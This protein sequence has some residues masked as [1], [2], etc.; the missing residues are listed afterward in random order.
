M[1]LYSTLHELLCASFE[2][3]S[4]NLLFQNPAVPNSRDLDYSTLV[5]RCP[6]PFSSSYSTLCTCKFL[7]PPRVAESFYSDGVSQDDLRAELKRQWSIHTAEVRGMRAKEWPSGAPEP[8]YRRFGRPADAFTLDNERY[9]YWGSNWDSLWMVAPL[10]MDA[11]CTP[12]SSTPCEH[13]NSGA[14]YVATRLRMNLTD[15]NLEFAVLCFAWARLLLPTF[16]TNAEAELW[17]FDN[18][19]GVSDAH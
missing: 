9:T 11:I 16:L 17:A 3:T 19:E 5:G 18:G 8:S 13:L 15:D 7:H 4:T 14:R 12:A 1:L 2:L 6:Q 10:I